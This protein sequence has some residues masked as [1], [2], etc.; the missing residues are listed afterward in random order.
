[1]IEQNYLTQLSWTRKQKL[2]LDWNFD[3]LYQKFHNRIYNSPNNY[4]AVV[5]WHINDILVCSKYVVCTKFGMWYKPCWLLFIVCSVHFLFVLSMSC[6]MVQKSQRIGWNDQNLQNFVD[7]Y[8][9]NKISK[10]SS[11]LKPV[12]RRGCAILFHLSSSIDRYIHNI[13]SNLFQ[14]PI[15]SLHLSSC[16]SIVSLSLYC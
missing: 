14:I 10:L 5:A 2:I 8:I 13:Q 11:S 4:H 9:E 3:R 7:E 16:K 6:G 1:M 12:Q 15:H